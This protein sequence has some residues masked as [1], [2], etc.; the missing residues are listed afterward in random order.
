LAWIRVF[1][2]TV[3]EIAIGYGFIALWLLAPLSAEKNR[4]THNGKTSKLTAGIRSWRR[5][6]VT[7]LTAVLIA[8]AGW[9]I[10]QRYFNPD[11]RVTFLSVGEGDGAVVRFPGSRVMLIDAGGGAPGSFDPGQNIVAPYLWANKIMHVD[12]MALSHPDRD[13][14]GGFIFIARNFTPSE[15]WTGGTTSND[16]SYATLVDAVRIAGAHPRL[17]NAA[18][19]PMTIAGVDLRCVG[20]L[21]GVHQTKDNNASM[22]IRLSY[23]HTVLLFPGDLEAKAERELIAA[24]EPL[25]ATILKV[26]HHGSRTS[27]SVQFLAAVRPA[28]AVISLGY[29][30]R[31]HFPAPEVLGRYADDRIPVL[32]TDEVG[33]VNVDASSDK[34]RIWSFRDGA[35]SIRR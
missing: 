1:T 17:C 28:E 5:A 13:H 29:H 10:L 30:N 31:F 8:D 19:P 32:R 11:L 22:V 18:S 20:P 9:W 15:F 35:F 16:S 2:P 21:P 27:S 34:L 12:Y 26:P 23:G 33:A 14:F 25:R 4:A 3:L 6:A 24:G 7:I